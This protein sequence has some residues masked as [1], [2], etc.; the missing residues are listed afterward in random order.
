MVLPDIRESFLV[1]S[2]RLL[3]TLLLYRHIHKTGNFIKWN[4]EVVSKTLDY[5]TLDLNQLM[6]FLEAN[7]LVIC[8][9]AQVLKQYPCRFQGNINV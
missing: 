1:T 8:K 7:D 9:Y 2:K 3:N 4:F 6:Y 5:S